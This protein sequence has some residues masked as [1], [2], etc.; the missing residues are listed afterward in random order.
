M[1]L[2]LKYKTD[3]LRVQNDRQKRDWCDVPLCTKNSDHTI[4][5]RNLVQISTRLLHCRK[6]KKVGFMPQNQPKKELVRRGV[7]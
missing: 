1:Y 7:F 5:V 3:F 4:L 6:L 2:T